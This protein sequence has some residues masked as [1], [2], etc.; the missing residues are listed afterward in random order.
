MNLLN[1]VKLCQRQKTYTIH[2]RQFQKDSS[3]CDNG[4]ERLNVKCVPVEQREMLE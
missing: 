1:A 4:Y 2:S 3:E